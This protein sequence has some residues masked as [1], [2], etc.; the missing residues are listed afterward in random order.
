[1]R[2]VWACRFD[3]DGEPGAVAPRLRAVARHWA[4]ATHGGWPEGMSPEA[5]VWS[6]SGGA[7]SLSWRTV[8][9]GAERVWELTVDEPFASDLSLRTITLT[10]VG[11]VAGRAYAFARLS[12]R[13]SG[14]VVGGP[15]ALTFRPPDLVAR[16]LAAGVAVDA[17]M[18]LTGAPTP[19]P[20][21]ATTATLVTHPRRHLPVLV[22]DRGAVRAGVAGDDLADLLVGLAHV[23]VVDR[24]IV[25]RLLNPAL[26]PPAAGARLLWPNVGPDDPEGPH[27]AFS[28]SELA[29]TTW[30]VPGWPV[31]RVLFDAA[32][33]HLQPP[34]AADRLEASRA[35]HRIAAARQQARGEVE[36]VL[37]EWERDLVEL[38]EARRARDEAEERARST[39]ARYADLLDGFHQ[40]VE[41]T[42]AERRVAAGGADGRRFTDLAAAV[43]A[44]AGAATTIEVLPSALTS[45]AGHPYQRPDKV[46][47][48]LLVLDQL[49]QRW[50]HNRLDGSFSQEALA[51]GLPW[52]GGVS[53]TARAR[54]G[55]MYTFRWN[56]A[57]VMAGPHLRYG[58]GGPPARHCRVYLALD[59]ESRTVI[60]CHAGRH[61]PDATSSAT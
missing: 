5:G 57:A 6:P 47:D 32:S 23:V 45:A 52:S 40:L 61:L 27:R 50:R 8:G 34:V 39:E 12:V 35:R 58:G 24:D 53:T 25:A 37:A 26:A 33:V 44:A 16:L 2:H 43:A 54:F 22:L 56:G 30:E 29:G 36:Q 7:T 38:G 49:A 15:V 51:A 18:R 28:A 13:S 21:G 3:F 46:Y 9:D 17:D 60:V 42:V 41:R 20:D 19:D 48:D 14:S 1:M 10:Q 55:A 11:E 4:A 59:F 31:A